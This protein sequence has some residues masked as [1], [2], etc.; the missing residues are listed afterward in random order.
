MWEDISWFILK[1]NGIIKVNH[2]FMLSTLAK[3]QGQIV[4]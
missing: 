2:I 3:I 4:E 1:E